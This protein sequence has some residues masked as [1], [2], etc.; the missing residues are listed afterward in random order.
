MIHVTAG[1]N[2]PEFGRLVD[3]GG[4]V[5][6]GLG[7]FYVIDLPADGVDSMVA[8]EVGGDVVHHAVVV[9]V[10]DG[11]AGLDRAGVRP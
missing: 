5:L 4:A 2:I 8:S 6:A 9:E 11:R 3:D 1:L 10:H 7:V